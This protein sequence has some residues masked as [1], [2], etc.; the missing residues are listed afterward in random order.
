MLLPHVL[1]IFVSLDKTDFSECVNFSVSRDVCI[2]HQRNSAFFFFL[3]KEW[4]SKLIIIGNR[5]LRGDESKLV[6]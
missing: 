3:V 5:V 4:F 2:Q 6:T 1:F